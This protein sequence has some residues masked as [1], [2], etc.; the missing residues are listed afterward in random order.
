MMLFTVTACNSRIENVSY[1]NDIQPILNDYCVDCHN[2]D[3]KRGNLNFENYDSM[4]ASRYLKRNYPV[5]ITKDPSM[6]RLYLVVRSNK[7]SIRMP[8]EFLGYDRLS[9]SDIETI[10]VWIAHGAKNN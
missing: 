4:M 2:S 7:S 10:R 1:K 8:P 9:D 5:V 6:S 3:V